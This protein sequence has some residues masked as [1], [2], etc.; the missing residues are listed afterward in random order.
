MKVYI[1]WGDW[2]LVG[3]YSTK[4]KAE[5]ASLKSWQ[6]MWGKDHPAFQIRKGM[7]LIPNVQEVELD[8]VLNIDTG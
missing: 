2:T 1:A 5:N 8:T 7:G 6:K 4:R 3:I